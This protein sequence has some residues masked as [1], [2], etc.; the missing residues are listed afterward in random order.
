M[1]KETVLPKNIRQ[2][3]DIQGREKICVE[4]YVMTYIRKKEPQEEK[5]FLGIFLGETKET[6]EAGYIFVRGIL[7]VPNEEEKEKIQEQLEKQR[8][9]YF[10]GW[11]ILGC[12]VI[13]AY[14][15]KRMELVTSLQPQCRRLI[16]H[17]QEQEETLHLL[18]GESYRNVRGYLVFYEQ[19]RNMQDYLADVFGENSVEKESLPDKAIKSFREKVKEKSEQKTH[20]MLK[21]ASSF[22][23]VTVLA[24]GVIVVNRIDGIQSVGSRSIL[25]QTLQSQSDEETAKVQQEG[26]ENSTAVSAQVSNNTTAA[27]TEALSGTGSVQRAS[28][29]SDT[30][31]SEAA[32]GTTVVS[33]GATEYTAAASSEDSVGAVEDT[34]RTQSDSALSSSEDT[35]QPDSVESSTQMAGSDAFWETDP[36]EPKDTA[37]SESSEAASRQLQASYVIREGDT[38]ANI[39]K[40]YYG[41]LEHLDEICEANEITDANVILPGQKIV[42][43]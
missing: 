35:A 13:G 6:E 40:K 32:S 33:A 30:V 34:V 12:C 19:N 17:L 4:D 22:F 5:G 16:Y 43:P 31:Q 23:V 7:E 28:A 20:S 1:G 27:Q 38:L 10:P 18:D 37:E 41:S 26:E 2:I 36:D 39:C 29:G 21:L 9:E 15:T 14:P 11:D 25:S 3:G 24:I 42:L 8:M